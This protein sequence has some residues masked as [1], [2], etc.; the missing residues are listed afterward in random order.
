M[1]KREK[2]QREL[3][4]QLTQENEMLTQENEM[5]RTMLD[6][7]SK[8]AQGVAAGSVE[9]DISATPEAFYKNRPV[10]KHLTSDLRLMKG[11]FD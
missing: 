2:K 8:P 9:P 3:I 4:D 5:L 7:T 6:K 1:T 11:R 10:L